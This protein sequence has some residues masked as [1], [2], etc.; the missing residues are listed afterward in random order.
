MPKKGKGKSKSGKRRFGANVGRT[1]DRDKEGSKNFSYLNISKD[2]PVYKE[3]P[4][5]GKDKAK[6]DIIPYNV[7]VNNHPDYKEDDED[8]ATKGDLWWRR[9]IQIHRNIGAENETVMCPKTIGK[10]CPI[11]VE[12]DKQYKEGVPSDKVKGKS[13][14]RDLFYIIPRGQKDYE[15]I[16]HLWDISKF[17]FGDEL[18]Q[19][20]DE[21][22][23]FLAFPDMDAGYT[24][25]VRFFQDSFGGNKFAKANRIDFKKRK[26]EIDDDILKGYPSLDEVFNVKSYK[27]LEAMFHAISEEDVVD[28]KDDDAPWDDTDEDTNSGSSKRKKKGG[29]KDKKKKELEDMEESPSFA[30]PPKKKKKEKEEEPVKRKKK[31]KK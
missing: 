30:N 16:P 5:K 11:C 25:S 31:K 14:F 8:S 1:V 2:I 27:E 18:L 19:D 17:C 6:M 24:L 29:K 10:K 26:Y 4:S 22:P 15:E 20:V 28:D 12:K 9:P 13:S 21:D 23:D 7:T 3:T